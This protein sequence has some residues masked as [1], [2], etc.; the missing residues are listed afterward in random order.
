MKLL[1]ENGINVNY[2]N[3]CGSTALIW[4]CSKSNP[5]L[6]RILINKGALINFQDHEKHNAIQMAAHAGK[7]WKFFSKCSTSDKFLHVF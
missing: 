2:L 5:N 4:A 7:L 6:A 3:G 1:I